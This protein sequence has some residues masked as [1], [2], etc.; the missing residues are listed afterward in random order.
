MACQCT[1]FEAVLIV[2]NPD[3]TTTISFEVTNA[4]QTAVS[5]IA[6]GTDGLVVV[7][8]SKGT[9]ISVDGNGDSYSVDYTG[10]GGRNPGFP[11]IKFTSA[12]QDFK[13][14]SS[15]IFTIT[16]RGYYPGYT[17][18]LQTHIGG[19]YTTYT[20]VD[21]SNCICPQG[22]CPYVPPCPP[23]Y[24]RNPD[25]TCSETECA[26]IAPDGQKWVCV[27][28]GNPKDPWRLTTIPEGGQIPDGGFELGDNID[29]T[30]SSGYKLTCDCKRRIFPCANRCCGMGTCDDRIGV[31]TCQVQG[32]SGA[33]CC[34]YTPPSTTGGTG[35]SGATTGT[36][37]PST[38]GSTA[39]TG[40][41][42]PPLPCYNNGNFC[43]GRG[44]CTGTTC[45]CNYVG[46]DG[47]TYTG[48]FCDVAV[49]PPNCYDYSSDCTGCL[50]APAELNCAWCGDVGGDY[51]GS[52]CPV[53]DQKL[54]CDATVI[55]YVPGECQSDEDCSSKGSCV[56]SEEGN[57]CV[58][59]DGERG[60]D[61]GSGGLSNLG[62]ALA[63]SGGI[64]ALIV[65]G[66][67]AA[68]VL[69]GFGVKKG[70]DF[71]AL[72]EMNMAA[73]NENPLYIGQTQEHRNPLADN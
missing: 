9:Y 70:V 33:D 56:E 23:G 28:T 63:I 36:N 2:E 53:E 65:I 44:I 29:Q 62:K 20:G 45:D 24:A 26:D 73:S 27:P 34:T 68:L 40:S 51:C 31:C 1:S 39:T 41:N 57:Y 49:V 48:D 4:C 8:P 55:P 19:Q 5:Y 60:V 38:G 42:P 16:V 69:L 6:I 13:L 46:A 18:S 12:N 21:L 22:G 25:Q 50:N 43:N 64:I 32:A 7:A 14:G 10:D 47:V 11:S 30:D 71:I 59:D 37:G 54:S 35:G 67:V 52:D 66:G 61:C 58:C 15:D 17:F 72:R 3:G